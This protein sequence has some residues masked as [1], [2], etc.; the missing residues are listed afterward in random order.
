MAFQTKTLY[1]TLMEILKFRGKTI[2]A[3]DVIFINELIAKY[4]A[5]SRR[6]LSR[7]LCEAWGWRQ[8]NGHLR[9]MVCRTLMLQLHRAGHIILPPVRQHN[10]NPLANRKRPDKVIDFDETLLCCALKEVQPLNIQ[11]VSG[12]KHEKLFNSLIETYHYLGYSHPVGETM[13]HMVFH[14][15]RPIACVSWCSAALRLGL[16]DKHIGW[17]SDVRQKNLKYLACNT[18]YLIMPW[19]NIP[20]LASHLLGCL[21]RGLSDQWV[22]RHGHPLYYLETFVQPDLYKGTCYKAANWKPLGLTSGKGVKGKSS[23]KNVPVKELLVLPI[24]KRYKRKL[25]NEQAT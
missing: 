3:Q 24:D 10:L 20:H 12:T 14:K 5:S 15:D 16:R 4:P 7:L 2:T 9:D 25:N 6:E 17:S 18:R 11:I 21:S 19:V 22:Q 23:K 13:K 8:A 1:S